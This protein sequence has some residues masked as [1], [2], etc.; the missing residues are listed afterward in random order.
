MTPLVLG[1]SRHYSCRRNGSAAAVRYVADSDDGADTKRT[2]RND[3]RRRPETSMVRRGLRFES[4]RGLCKCAGN[5]R[6][7]IQIDLLQLERAVGME[8]LWSFHIQTASGV[9]VV[10]ELWVPHLQRRQR[11]EF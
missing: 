3:T 7:S 4:G 6:F 11:L 10:H 8:P 2:F 5:R 1:T 9:R